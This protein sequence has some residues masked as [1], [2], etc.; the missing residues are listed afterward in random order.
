MCLYLKTGLKHR[1]ANGTGILNQGQKDIQGYTNEANH[2]DISM[3]VCDLTKPLGSVRAMVKAGNRIVFD[4]GGSYIQHKATG[5]KTVIEDR[6]G[7]F[8]FDIWVPRGED[9]GHQGK[10]KALEEEEDNMGFVGLDT[11]L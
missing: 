6:N 11:C 1:A 8:V 10:F 3:Q 2:V 5:A 9:N 4:E 7:A